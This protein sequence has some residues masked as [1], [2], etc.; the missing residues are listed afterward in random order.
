MLHAK[1]CRIAVGNTD[2][3]YI[4][5]GQGERPLVMLPGLGDALK[6]VKGTALRFALAYRAF[7]KN[8]TVYMFSRKNRMPAQYSIRDMAEDQAQAMRSLGITDACVMGVS[9]GGMIAMHLAAAHPELVSRLVLA[10]TAATCNGTMERVV[11]NWLRLSEA[12]DFKG[13]FIDSAEKTYTEKKLKQYR[14]LYPILAAASRPKS[15]ERFITQ[16]SACLH[17]DASD[18]LKKIGCPALVIGGDCDRIVGA[19]SAVALAKQIADCQL[20]ICK[21]YGH[22]AFEECSSFQ[23]RVLD[24]FHA[25]S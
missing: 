9:Q 4:T 22:G 12:D 16:A 25:E 8:H 6:T 10:N 7:A 3:D 11:E 19:E 15:L 24:F 21:G 1:N 18:A 17:H 14:P 5:F 23:A 20:M 13:L 2:M